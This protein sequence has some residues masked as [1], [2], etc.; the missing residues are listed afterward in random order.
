ME[1]LLI[2]HTRLIVYS[3]NRFINGKKL[4]CHINKHVYQL[5]NTQQNAPGRCSHIIITP[6]RGPPTLNNR[7]SIIPK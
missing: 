7:P 2:T 6:Q 1:Q 5:T 4:A 3:S